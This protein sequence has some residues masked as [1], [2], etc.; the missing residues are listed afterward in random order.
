MTD[1]LEQLL[2]RLEE[3]EEKETSITAQSAWNPQTGTAG[4][5][6]A[7]RL[8][9]PARQ[10]EKAPAL[11]GQVSPE[12]GGSVWERDIQTPGTE[13]D[14]ET[15]SSEQD[16]QTANS[17]RAIQAPDSEWAVQT[18]DS[19]RVIQPLD[20]GP[21]AQGRKFQAGLDGDRR[22]RLFPPGMEKAF[23]SGME[24][25]FTESTEDALF[26][27]TQ[28][29]PFYGKE[30]AAFYGTE[31]SAMAGAVDM[32]HYGASRLPLRA[33]EE[34]RDAL[35][36]GG[37]APS[38]WDG[39]RLSGEYWGAAPVQRTPAAS[40]GSAAAMLEQRLAQSMAWTAAPRAPGT[41]A[42]QDV[43]GTELDL[44]ELDQKVR[45]DARRYDGVLTPY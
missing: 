28:G 8:E 27:G 30:G 7:G 4:H 10:G 5:S 15:P 31:D 18:S 22:W 41:A 12:A 19:E 33:V 1:Y 13:R 14:I 26:Y 40:F 35:D 34:A 23:A 43:I 39:A 32:P 42:A 25:T 16:V 38:R 9:E 44:E 6:H 37:S 21:H 29:A 17:E 24:E 45:R 11:A 3:P 20:S 2:E 36:R